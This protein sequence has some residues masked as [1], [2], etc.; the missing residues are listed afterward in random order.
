MSSSGDG[1]TID[2]RFLDTLPDGAFTVDR[3]WRITAFN[4]AAERITGFSRD[5]VVGRPCREVFRSSICQ[6]GCGIQRAVRSGEPVMMRCL[7][8][9][10]ASGARV[11]VCISAGVLRDEQGEIVGAIE[12]FR[13]LSRIER[14]ETTCPEPG[15]PG[16]VGNSPPVSRLFHLVRLVAATDST[17]LIEG[18]SG[19]GKE[20]VARAIHG[21]SRRG[22]KPLVAVNCGALPDTLLESELFGH[23]AGSFTDARRDKPG[24]FEV[25]NGGT[26]L[27]DEIGEVSPALQLRLLRVLQER[28]I[29]PLGSTRPV[30]VDVRIL[31]ATNRDLFERV[32]RGLFRRDLFY[33]INVVR[34]PVPPLRERLEDL[35]LLVDA[36]LRHL[37]DAGGRQIDGVSPEA[38][39]IL[40][41]YDYPGNVRELQNILEHAAVFCTDG[42]VLPQHLPEHLS[43]VRPVAR[44][45]A[46]PVQS[47]QRSLILSALARHRGNRRATAK[48]LGIHP[49]TLW[50]RAQRLGIDL[51]DEDGR[52]SS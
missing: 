12:T 13:E 31:A 23:R 15:L 44:P 38:M 3:E 21:L 45:L 42:V 51:P 19:T 41:A 24:R 5:E 18:E 17:A 40:L 47:L 29:E 39:E 27:L 49:T 34:I 28:E 11:P 26:I 50:R 10:T 2:E 16:F 32:E 30:R 4:Q 9:G 14:V 7:S 33:R 20:L 35:P 8:I 52:T 46:D 22:D 36:Y 37:N 48:E 25:A 43:H 1:T 6:E